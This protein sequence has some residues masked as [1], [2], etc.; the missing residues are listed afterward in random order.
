MMT[1]LGSD[2]IGQGR[3][4]SVSEKKKKLQPTVE[5][6]AKQERDKKLEAAIKEKQQRDEKKVEEYGKEKRREAS[7]GKKF[8]RAVR[9]D[10]KNMG[11]MF[12]SEEDNE[13]T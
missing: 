8:S 10:V 2:V 11:G 12:S 13:E 4:E 6:L 7:L 5:E 3:D 1:R 9:R